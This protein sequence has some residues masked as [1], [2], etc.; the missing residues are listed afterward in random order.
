[1]TL[2]PR[3]RDGQTI[4]ELVMFMALFGVGF[5]VGHFV[6]LIAG[7]VPGIIAGFMTCYAVAVGASLIFGVAGK[8]FGRKQ[9]RSAAKDD[10]EKTEPVSGGNR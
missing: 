10:P 4:I 9:S 3:H 5:V 8:R 1:M 7:V 2:A 6:A